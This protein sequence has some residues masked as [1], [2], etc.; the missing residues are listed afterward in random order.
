MANPALALTEP[1]PPS[2]LAR[3]NVAGTERA[4]SVAFGGLL[5][6]YGLHHRRSA[7]G[8]ASTVLAGLMLERGVTGRCVAYRALGVDTAAPSAVQVRQAMQ[9]EKPR[10]EVY[11]FF[12]D[13]ANL[14]KFL[15]HVR[16]VEVHEGGRSHWTV[17]VAPAPPVEWDAVIVDD[18][19]G[20]RV[21]WRTLEGSALEN[22]GEVRFAELPGGRGTGLFVDL[23][24][25]PRPGAISA[26]AGHLLKRLTEQRIR[27]DLRRLKNVMEAGEIPSTGG[28][29]SGEGRGEDEPGGGWRQALAGRL[30]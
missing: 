12:R 27:E 8:W 19:P 13:L 7:T 18:R 6:Y 24:Y 29:P 28:Q 10:Q 2:L 11:G 26:A 20:E 9:I 5:A 15:K 4:L 14:P 1:A 3:P 17:Q 25:R 21:A 23:A 16:S 22:A 30:Q